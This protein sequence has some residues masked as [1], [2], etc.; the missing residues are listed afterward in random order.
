MGDRPATLIAAL[1]L[2]CCGVFAIMAQPILVEVM[3]DGLGLPAGTAAG[4]TAVE[5][6][7]TAL[8]PVLA[9]FWMQRL[10]WRPTA[11]A[12]L[13]VV[14]GGN[15]LSALEQDATTLMVLRFLIGI[16]GE[17]TAFALAMA[18][19][20]QT[21]QKDR[22]FALLVAAQVALGV[23]F[24]LF[25]PMPHDAGM[26]GVT[27]PMA[28]LAILALLATSRIPRPATGS[29]RQA[30]AGS[31]IATAPSAPAYGA[32]V[33]MLAWCTGLGAI[34]AFIKLIGVDLICHDCGTADKA[35]AALRI[36]QALG[37]STGIGVVGALA[38][39]MLADRFG[40]LLPVTAALLVQLAMVLLLRNEMAWLQ[41]ALT[42][43][44]FQA[45]WNMTGPYIM[46]T[47]AL[48]DATGRAS[49]LIPTA[50]IG[51]FFLGPTLVKFFL[52]GDG[53]VAANHVAALCFVV[54]LV[55]FIPIAGRIGKTASAPAH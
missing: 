47:I 5:A 23:A 46:G 35:E 13:L 26:A 18:I 40:R 1:L 6:L 25:L 14:I 28:G 43:A 38:A 29:S 8:G 12:A 7:G 50:Q 52:A 19:L 20:S 21:A 16:L 44:T 53:Y 34:W 10:P 22:N 33:V 32:L 3:V 37:L 45:F 31:S 51:G 36:G 54:A 48:G 41:F 11:A 24:F 42:A 39:A 17:G 55:L 2:G 15:L 49:L 9:L 30:V 4:I 27:L